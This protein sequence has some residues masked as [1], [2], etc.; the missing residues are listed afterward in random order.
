MIFNSDDN[1]EIKNFLST[2]IDSIWSDSIE[3]KNEIKYLRYLYL[4]LVGTTID[5]RGIVIFD[6]M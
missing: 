1:G 4:F 5:K 6:I 3:L 2:I